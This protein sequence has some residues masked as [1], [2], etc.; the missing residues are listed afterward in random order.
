MVKHT[1]TICRQFAGELFECFDHFVRLTLKG[2]KWIITLAIE[3]VVCPR[4]E[5][6]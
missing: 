4:K 5:V 3:L 1:Q 2:L 6:L